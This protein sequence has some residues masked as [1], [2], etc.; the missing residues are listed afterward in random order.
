MD[1]VSDWQKTAKPCRGVGAASAALPPEAQVEMVEQSLWTRQPTER[2]LP[3]APRLALLRR[4]L[5]IGGTIALTAL[6]AYQMYLVLTVNGLTLLQAIVLGLYVALFAW[7]AFSFMT[8]IIGFF[9]YVFGD[10]GSLKI[11]PEEEPLP[12]ITTRCAL[13]VPTYNEEPRRLFARVEAI[14]ESVALTRRTAH[15]DVFVLSDTADPEIWIE[16]EMRFFELQ[17]RT[18]ARGGIFYRHRSNNEG[19]KAGNIA[20]WTRRFGGHYQSMIV[21]DADS[22]MTGSTIVRLVDAL[23][24]HPHVGLIQTLPTIVNATTLFARLQQFASRVYGP[25]IGYGISSWHCAEG[26]YWGHNAI[27]RVSA[28][29]GA[30][31][32]PTLRGRPPFGGPIMSHDFV[33]AALMRRMGWAVHVTPGLTGSYEE[34]PP[35]LDDYTARGRRRCQGNL[36]HTAVLAARG[37][38][39][40]SRLHLLTGIGSYVTAPMWLGFLLLGVLISL[41]AHFIR[42]EYFA[43]G[44]SLFPMWPTED[45]YRAAFVFTGTMGILIFPKILGFVAL[46]LNRIERRG[47]ARLVFSL[48]VEIIISG[49][50]APVM[51]WRQSVA[52]I[53]ILLGKDAG[54]SAQ[55]RQGVS[56]PFKATL[57]RYASPTVVGAALAAA[58]YAVSV[59]LFLWMSPV[60]LGLL[61]ASPM[62]AL[63]A[64]S[65]LGHATRRLGLLLT[66]EERHPP[67]IVRQANELAS[68]LR[69]SEPRSRLWE[70]LLLGSTFSMQHREMLPEAAPRRFGQVNID[71]VIGFAKLDQCA[72][73]GD[74]FQILSRKELKELLGNREAFDRLKALGKHGQSHRP[75]A[76]NRTTTMPAMQVAE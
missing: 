20:D 60:I 24:R 38:H 44:F 68:T 12:E 37:L 22:L 40:V 70:E 29:A 74:A 61:L 5:V 8:V 30:A 72:T 42:P 39:W 41:Q 19:R 6:A 48:V 53:Q 54:W 64:S 25:L 69:S 63:T 75:A 58:A 27:I 9:A 17:D 51:M 56:T 23:E 49:L 11:H 76:Y 26:N 33:E 43:P 36:Q 1:A 59:P 73:I 62:A 45:P 2:R 65:A 28:F 3:M 7:I 13:L 10:A 35:S 57:R 50:L 18:T 55:Q 14:F 4:V 32:L 16:E 34:S 31:G 15:F 46:L 21:L 66:P 47:L 52:V 71:L 67:D